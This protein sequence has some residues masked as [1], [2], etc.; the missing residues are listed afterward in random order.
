MRRFILEYRYLLLAA[1]V[2]VVAAVT[3]YHLSSPPEHRSVAVP[4]SSPIRKP[5]PLAEAYKQIKTIADDPK[6][7]TGSQLKELLG[8]PNLTEHLYGTQCE[9]WTWQDDHA[10][11]M[12]LVIGGGNGP[13]YGKYF[14]KR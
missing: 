9:A 10:T 6:H 3:I 13:A 12:V 2:T 5:V 7:M 14:Y 1:L 11:V 8:E 4:D